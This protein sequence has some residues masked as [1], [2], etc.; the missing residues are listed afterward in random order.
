MCQDIGSELDPR[1]GRA[2]ASEERQIQAV[3]DLG[4]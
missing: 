1:N 3:H 2:A 4:P